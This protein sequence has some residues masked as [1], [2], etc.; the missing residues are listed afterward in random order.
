MFSK[1]EPANRN[2][3]VQLGLTQLIF[4]DNIVQVLQPILASFD[5]LIEWTFNTLFFQG[6]SI[7]LSA[8]TRS[9]SITYN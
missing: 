3:I 7:K 9:F 8:N 5:E 1:G 6:L 2:A 4:Q